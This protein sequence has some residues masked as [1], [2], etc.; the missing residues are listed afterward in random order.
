MQFDYV[1]LLFHSKPP[2]DIAELNPPEL[3]ACAC[4]FL[5]G[6]AKI[7]LL[8]IFS[9]LGFP[10][11]GGVSCFRTSST[12]RGRKGVRIRTLSLFLGKLALSS[13]AIFEVVLVLRVRHSPGIVA[14]DKLTYKYL[15]LCI[16]RYFATRWMIGNK[17]SRFFGCLFAS[18]H[19]RTSDL[20]DRNRKLITRWRL[21]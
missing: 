20:I 5:V 4:P 10:T 15:W 21:Q 13:S 17:D 12:T 6:S 16:P 7:Y 1:H 14:T 19:S 11:R 18:S 2:G 8:E 3:V 9:T